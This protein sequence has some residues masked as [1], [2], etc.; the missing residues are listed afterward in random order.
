[1]N[2]K[3]VAFA[4]VFIAS[5]VIS[6]CTHSWIPFLCVMLPLVAFLVALL[7]LDWAHS[8]AEQYAESGIEHPNLT[9][10]RVE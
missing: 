8:K 10:E 9:D 6:V 5:E 7:A 1:M 3:A 2:P 4:V